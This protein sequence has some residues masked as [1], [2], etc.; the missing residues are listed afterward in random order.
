MAAPIVWTTTRD[1]L[2]AALASITPDTLPQRL[3]CA[4]SG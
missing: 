4:L 1:T 3:T 2:V